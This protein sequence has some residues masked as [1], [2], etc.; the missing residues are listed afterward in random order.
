VVEQLGAVTKDRESIRSDLTADLENERDARRRLQREVQQK[1]DTLHELEK[2]R[3]VL[4][5]IDADADIYLVSH[6]MVCRCIPLTS[7]CVQFHER[8]LRRGEKGG[9]EAAD[10][11]M[12]KVREYVSSYV[13]DSQNIRVMVKCYANLTGLAQAYMKRSKKTAANNFNQLVVGFTRR[14]DLFDFV[15]VGAGKEETDSKIRGMAPWA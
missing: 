4:V 3:H 13:T 12:A 6:C 9:E 2:S 8:Y 15:D 10:D 14:Y 11:L 5:L 1:T 7:W